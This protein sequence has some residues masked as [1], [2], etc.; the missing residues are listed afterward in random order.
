[1]ANYHVAKQQNI[2]GTERTVYYKEG[3]SWTTEFAD[4]KKYTNKSTATGEIY[5]FGGTVITE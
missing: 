5:S 2:L 1:M 4:R 3:T